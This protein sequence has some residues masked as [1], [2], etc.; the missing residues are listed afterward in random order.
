MQLKNFKP[1]EFVDEATYKLHG[2][3]SIGI[4]DKSL[5]V[6]IDSFHEHLQ[7]KYKGSRISINVNDWKW[8]GRFSWRGIRTTKYY[9]TPADFDRSRSQHK[10]GRGLDFDVYI[11]GTRVDPTT[12]RSWIIDLR[13]EPWV[14]PITFIEDGVNWVHVDTRYDPVN[15]LVLW[16][17]GTGESVCYQ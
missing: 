7:T 15:F 9:A 14:E 4:M 6:F 12:V 13:H 11:D 3:K 5:L 16:H 2:D 8:G 10:Y 17:V 1:F